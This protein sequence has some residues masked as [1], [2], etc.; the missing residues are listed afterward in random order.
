MAYSGT[1]VGRSGR[2]TGAVRIGFD[3]TAVHAGVGIEFEWSN[4][5]KLKLGA[6][7]AKGDLGTAERYMI[8]ALIPFD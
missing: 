6:Q 8:E 2:F 3:D 5:A 4:H 7:H 1:F